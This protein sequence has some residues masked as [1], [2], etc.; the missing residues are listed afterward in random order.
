MTTLQVDVE[1]CVNTWQK[2]AWNMKRKC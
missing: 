2:E 1:R